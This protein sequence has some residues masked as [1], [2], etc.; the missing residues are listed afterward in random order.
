MAVY[1]DRSYL[2][3]I[4]KRFSEE[5]ILDIIQEPLIVLDGD[6]RIV[7]VNESFLN[8][9]NVDSSDTVVNLINDLFKQEVDDLRMLLTD[10]L[11]ESSQIKNYI[12]NLKSEN[13]KSRILNLNA[14]CFN[15]ENQNPMILISLNDITEHKKTEE[16]LRESEKRFKAVQ[17]NSLDRFTI[18]KP[19]YDDQDEIIDFTLYIRM[20][21]LQK[22][23]A[24]PLK[25][26]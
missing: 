22:T 25:N 17:E 14:R 15:G 16:K 20:L 5:C 7:K 4:S 10:I 24:E 11:L 3:N 8:Y 26:L 9:F 18:L 21:M 2:E 19:L 12:L 1:S 6:L 13:K 23:Q